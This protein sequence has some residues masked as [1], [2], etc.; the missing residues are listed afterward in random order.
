MRRKF[1]EEIRVYVWLI[2]FAVQQKAIQHC[3]ATIW[4]FLKNG[5]KVLV[6]ITR[7]RKEVHG[8]QFRKT[9]STHSNSYFAT[10]S[11]LKA[12][13]LRL[14]VC[15]NPLRFYHTNTL[16]SNVWH[17]LYVW[18]LDLSASLIMVATR[19]S[20]PS[21]AEFLASIHIYWV[22]AF[23]LAL[24]HPSSASPTPVVLVI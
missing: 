6:N 9:H 8:R 19:F 10:P 24:L 14:P 16:E 4:Q 3:K 12:T 5:V 20:G 22:A 11:R 15:R 21:M 18:R 17:H 2:H 1:K 23:F 7:K 13:I